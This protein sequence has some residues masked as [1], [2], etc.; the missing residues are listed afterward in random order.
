MSEDL[1]VSEGAVC[2]IELTASQADKNQSR[3]ANIHLRR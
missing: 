1:V 3:S 2:M